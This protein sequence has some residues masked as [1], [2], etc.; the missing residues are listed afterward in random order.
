[1]ISSILLPIADAFP[2]VDVT[3]DGT[4]YQLQLEWNSREALWYMSVYLPGA[5]EDT[6]TPILLGQ[7]M[8]TGRPLLLGCVHADRPKGELVLVGA[9]DTDRTGFNTQTTLLYY[10]QSEGFGVP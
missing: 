8:V 1:M 3:L 5:T 9:V 10:D 7:P 6:R 2:L 4:A